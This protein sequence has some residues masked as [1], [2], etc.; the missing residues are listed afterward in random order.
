MEWPDTFAVD[1]HTLQHLVLVTNRLD[2]FLTYAM[3]FTGA[4]GAN[5]RILRLD[6]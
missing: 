4:H 1:L 6:L 3:D 5:M 2:Q